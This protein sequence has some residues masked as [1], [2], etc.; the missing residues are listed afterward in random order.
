MGWTVWGFPSGR[1]Y[2]YVSRLALGP[3]QTCIQWVL[4]ILLGINWPGHDVDHPSPYSTEVK[5]KVELYLCSTSWAFVAWSG[6][7]FNFYVI[8]VRSS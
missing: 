6:L 8:A 5:E 1:D 4:G 2:L 3:T 7:N